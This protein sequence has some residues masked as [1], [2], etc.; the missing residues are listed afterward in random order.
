MKALQI[1][2]L[3][4]LLVVTACATTVGT[5]HGQTSKLDA[6]ALR[7]DVEE[8]LKAASYALQPTPEGLNAMKQAEKSRQTWMTF[9][10]KENPS[11]GSTFDLVGK[12]NNRW[13]IVTFG[14][15]GFALR[16]HAW[17]DCSEWYEA[18]SKA[19]AK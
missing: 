12:S 2:L 7:T 13:N 10:F 5:W 4:I 16:Q 18:W 8:S 17:N 15:M 19:H 6:K 14:I 11:G 1:G 9:T 3:G